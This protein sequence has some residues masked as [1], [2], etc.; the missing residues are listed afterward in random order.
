MQ[1]AIAAA[2]SSFQVILFGKHNIPLFVIII[3]NSFGQRFLQ[4]IKFLILHPYPAM[5]KAVK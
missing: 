5:D 4:V 2:I 1:A 3:I